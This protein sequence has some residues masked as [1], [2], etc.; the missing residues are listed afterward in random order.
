M[1][2]TLD[3]GNTTTSIGVFS[4][5]EET[6]GTSLHA[7]FMS[8]ERTSDEAGLLLENLLASKGVPKDAMDGA[9]L[10][11]VVPSLENIWLRAVEEYFSLSPVV[12][13]DKLDLGIGIDMDF[14]GEVGADRLANA[15]GA[16]GKYG[17]PVV[18]VD[19]GTAIN[20]DVVSAERTYIGGAIAPGL[21]TSVKTLFSR[22]AKLPQVAL[23]TPP[24]AIGRNTVNAIQS[25]IVFGYT[26]LVDELVKRIL[27]ELGTKAPVVAT[28]GHAEVLASHSATIGA[29]D[30]RLT[31]EGLRI[32]YG[33]NKTRHGRVK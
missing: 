16:A 19:M 9:I 3:I 6:T 22:T 24:R 10:C 12:V 7:N 27:A 26:G 18:A 8:S 20:I 30:R 14:P 2:L 33:R 17:C 4:E 28:G 1:L 23:E 32:I 21:Q 13:S 5:T 31:L 25:G 11:C 29:V 15:V